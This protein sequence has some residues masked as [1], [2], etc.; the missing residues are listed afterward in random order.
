MHTY[1]H[2]YTHIHIHTHIHTYTHTHIHTYT[3]TH[4]PLYHAVISV[5]LSVFAVSPNLLYS[6]YTLYTPSPS[7]TPYTHPSPSPSP[8]NRIRYSKL[9]FV[10]NKLNRQY[11]FS[12]CKVLKFSASTVNQL[13]NQEQKR[14]KK[15]SGRNIGMQRSSYGSISSILYLYTPYNSYI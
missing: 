4:I 15:K 8:T 11:K 1:I 2:T 7:P 6:S 3:H 12:E 5:F 14:Q 9:F 10:L 13:R